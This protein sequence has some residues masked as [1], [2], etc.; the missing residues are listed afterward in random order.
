MSQF[1]VTIV[2]I[3]GRTAQKIKWKMKKID[4]KLVKKTTQAVHIL[5]IS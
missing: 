4:E 2:T 3:R 1:S 5:K